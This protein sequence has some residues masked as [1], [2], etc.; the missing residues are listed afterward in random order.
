[1]R[2]RIDGKENEKKTSGH[3]TRNRLKESRTIHTSYLFFLV[4]YIINKGG[5]SNQRDEEKKCTL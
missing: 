5:Q 4:L 2:Q 1:M 3:K